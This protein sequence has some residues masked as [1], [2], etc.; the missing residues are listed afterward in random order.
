MNIL[1]VEDDIEIRMLLDDALDEIA[2]VTFA[3]SADDGLATYM[4]QSF[5]CVIADH[6]LPGDVNGWQMLKTMRQLHRNTTYVLF[7][8]AILSDEERAGILQDNIILWEKP[9]MDLAF[10]EYLG[11]DKSNLA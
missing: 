11:K 7:T 8:G 2:N 1:I 5:D 9:N 4:T 3:S 6:I 10:L